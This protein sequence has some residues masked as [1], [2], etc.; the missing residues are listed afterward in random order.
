[1]LTPISLDLSNLQAIPISS[2]ISPAGN[3]G[4]PETYDVKTPAML[5]LVQRQITEM[6]HS[7]RFDISYKLYLLCGMSPKGAVVL[8][9][10]H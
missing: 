8:E 4:T 10:K 2:P 5:K 9:L 6:P 3:A 1:M 7:N